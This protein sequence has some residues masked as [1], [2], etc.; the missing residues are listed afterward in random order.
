V[1]TGRR[2]AQASHG[3]FHLC[4]QLKGYRIAVRCAALTL[5]ESK[6]SSSSSE[7]GQSCDH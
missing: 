7:Q 6:L 3:S 1:L 2:L 4:D 5:R